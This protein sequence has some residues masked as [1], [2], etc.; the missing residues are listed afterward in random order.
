MTHGDLGT[1]INAF[2][3]IKI[4]FTAFRFGEKKIIP[5]LLHLCELFFYFELVLKQV[6]G[7]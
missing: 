6:L 3:L 5:D 1:L 4:V 7:I 2:P